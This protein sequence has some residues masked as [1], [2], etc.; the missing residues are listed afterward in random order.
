MPISVLTQSTV[1][2]ALVWIRAYDTY[3][4]YLYK[5]KS[6]PNVKRNNFFVIPE[7]SLPDVTALQ[8]FLPSDVIELA[9][10]SGKTILTFAPT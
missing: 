6:F 4:I 10:V 8:D 5:D 2:S 1:E 7:R 3:N 9:V